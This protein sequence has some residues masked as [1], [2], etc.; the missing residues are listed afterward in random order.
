MALRSWLAS[1]VLAA[2]V[3][4][5]LAAVASGGNAFGTTYTVPCNGGD[6]AALIAAVNNANLTPT[7]DTMV[8]RPRY[9]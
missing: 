9:P 6:P 1:V 7:A 4:V 3:A 2:A 5:P 8:E